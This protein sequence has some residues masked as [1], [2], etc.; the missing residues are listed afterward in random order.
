MGGIEWLAS[1]GFLSHAFPHVHSFRIMIMHVA[2]YRHPSELRVRRN[3][4]QASQKFRFH[5]CPIVESCR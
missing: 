1:N 5:A 3:V 2:A 4:A